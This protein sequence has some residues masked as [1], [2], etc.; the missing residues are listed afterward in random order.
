MTRAI[1]EWQCISNG[2]GGKLEPMATSR[3]SN[4]LFIYNQYRRTS[5]AAQAYNTKKKKK[6]TMV[7]KMKGTHNAAS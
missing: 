6:K 5:D 2:G 1:C 3:M 7:E 4:M